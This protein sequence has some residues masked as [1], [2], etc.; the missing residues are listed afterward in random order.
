MAEFVKKEICSGVTFN[1]IIDDRFKTGR[2]GVTMLLPLTT[3]TAAANALAAL[4]LARSC[5]KYPT[6]ID[7]N[8]RFDNLYSVG[9]SSSVRKL[10]EYQAATIVLSGLD[11]RYALDDISISSEMTELLCD[12]IFDPNIKDGL[13]NADDIE[14]MRRQIIDSFDAE[15]N[16]KRT[17]AYNR[18]CDIMFKGEKFALNSFGSR[19]TV[20]ELQNS[21]IYDAWQRLLHESRVEIT[22][23]GNS[24]PEK[25]FEGFKDHFASDPRPVSFTPPVCVHPTEVKRVVETDNLSQSKLFMGFRGAYLRR[26]EDCLANSLMSMILGGTPTSKLFL[27][28]REKQSLCYYC[29]SRMD[30]NMGV[31]FI[32]SGVE[33]ENIEKTEQAVLEQINHMKSGGITDSE[34]EDAMLAARNMLLD[35]LDSLPALQSHFIGGL[36]REDPLSP[37]QALRILPSITKERV[38]EL[39]GQLELDT[40]YSLVGN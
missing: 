11:D 2:I 32:D 37:E 33:T 27:N 17:Y 16:D 8:R 12:L 9:I 24:S 35:S 21:D 13:F 25:A 3:E 26:D 36:V 22:M 28:V 5:R 4:V 39:A 31:M 10:G 1:S 38:I 18:C 15:Y 7:L 23:L 34:F 6:Y 30:N 20:M 14:Q 40:V 29:V 19:E